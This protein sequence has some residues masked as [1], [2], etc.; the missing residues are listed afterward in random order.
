MNKL[1]ITLLIALLLIPFALAGET[2]RIDFRDANTEAVSVSQGDRI[3]L[4][5]FNKEH[6]IIVNEIKDLSI[7]IGIFPY[8]M[9]PSQI[10]L[11]K[12]LTGKLDLNQDKADDIILQLYEVKN[13]TAILVFQES[14]PEQNKIAAKTINI[15]PTISSKNNLFLIIG[16]LFLIIIISTII[17]IRNKKQKFI[18]K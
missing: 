15:S 16:I 18:N 9:S 1:V 7:Q 13:N 4:T 2:I 14:N 3:I 5:Y 6:T 11:N 10:K 12:V 8:S 17:F